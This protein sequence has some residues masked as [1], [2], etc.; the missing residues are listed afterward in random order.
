MKTK[1]K[2]LVALD[3]EEQSMVALKYAE[4]YA[5]LL[6]YDLEVITVIEES[7]LLTKLFSNDD[8]LIKLNNEIA[9]RVEMAIKPYSEKIQINTHILHG[10]PYDKIA[11][12]ATEIQPAFIIMGKNEISK[13]AKSFLGSNSMHVILESGFPVLTIRGEYDFDKYKNENREILLPLD[14]KK[15]IRE[16]VSAAIE[17][18]KLFKMPIHLISIQ[19]TGGKG[20]EAKIITQLGL[21]K[22]TIVEAGIKCSSEVIIEPGKNIYELIGEQALKRNSALI[23]IMTRAENKLA[24]LF[25]GSNALD[26]INHSDIPVLSIQPWDQDSESSLFSM[27]SDPF[28]IFK[29]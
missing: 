22:K 20:R 10:K 5:K 9:R 16:Q 13:E 7:S 19:T 6:N 29:K 25:L 15:G 11:T 21:T 28:N 24:N 8:L 17:F 2:I 26:I 27:I 18:A 1:N 12:L 14:L 4:Y 3:L 23:V